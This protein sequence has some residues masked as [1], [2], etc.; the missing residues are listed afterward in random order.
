MKRNTTRKLHEGCDTRKTAV[1]MLW[2]KFKPD[3]LA[4]GILPGEQRS[5]ECITSEFCS[6]IWNRAAALNSFYEELHCL[7][8]IHLSTTGQHKAYELVESHLC[9]AQN[10]T[11]T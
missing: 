10:R 2:T 11:I 8:K 9:L 5:T 4:T 3:I 1:Q 6:L 7:G